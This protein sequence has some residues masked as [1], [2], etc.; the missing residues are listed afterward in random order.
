IARMLTGQARS[1]IRS[2][3]GQVEVGISGGPGDRINSALRELFAD[4]Y[5]W[6]KRSQGRLTPEYVT[7]DITALAWD[8]R[9][10]IGLQLVEREGKWY[11]DS[12]TNLPM[13][14]RA[15]P[16]DVNA[17]RILESLVATLDNAVL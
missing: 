1:P 5:G 3:A 14:R 15:F 7:D 13:V 11:L 4:P 12:P 6:L 10:V 8:G 16:A 2:R 9:G 17:Y